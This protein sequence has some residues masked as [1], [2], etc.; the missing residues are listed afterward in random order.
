MIIVMVSSPCEALL[1][2]EDELD[3]VFH[4]LSDR[5]R[6]ALI[7]RLARGPGIVTELAE[8]FE[9]TLGA[10]SKHLR[11][12]EAANLIRRDVNGKF[13]RCSLSAEPMVEAD[14]W[15]HEYRA[16]WQDSLNSLSWYANSIQSESNS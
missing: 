5:T 7:D 3:R 4:A 15:L 13:H 16:F 12:L 2:R 9:M 1:D 11:V 14:R 8:P 6:R 10:V